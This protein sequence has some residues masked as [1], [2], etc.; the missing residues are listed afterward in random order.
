MSVFIANFGEQN[1][2][3]PECVARSKIASYEDEDLQPLWLAGDREGYVES[4]IRT[5][6]TAAG[7]TP[8]RSVASRWFNIGHI[9]SSS[10]NDLWIH[11]E[12]DELWWTTSRPGDIETTLEPATKARVSTRGSER[13]FIRYKPADKWA[14]T[15]RKGNPLR[16]A[17]LHPTARTFLF[18]EGTLQQLTDGHAAYAQ[19]LISGDDLSAWHSLQR[20]RDRQ[21]AVRRTP[22]TIFNAR[23]RSVWE[24][25]NTVKQTVAGSYG[26]QVLRTVKNKELRFSSE[27]ELRR[28]IEA[29]ID[30]QDGLC[31]LTGIRLQ[32]AGDADDPDMLCSLDRIDSDGHYEAGNL[33]IVCR[34]ANRWKSDS[35][36]D[37]FRRLIGVVRATREG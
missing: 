28:H 8:T 29:L 21:E 35:K 18:T 23:Q 9:V 26:Q 17:A 10:E 1:L 7:I 4:A 5:I 33:Q 19:A 36:D 15:N 20:W 32:Y 2:L 11:R 25:V 24:M 12:K 27:E 3:W 30:V 34:F 31:A 6:V 16:W 22:G 37:E 14:N 13:V